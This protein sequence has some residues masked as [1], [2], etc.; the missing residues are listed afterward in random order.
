MGFGAVTV[1]G[2]Y[3]I[4]R[5]IGYQCAFELPEILFLSFRE[6]ISTTEFYALMCIL[7]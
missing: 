1:M 3:V 6:E 4:I 5:D 2:S 7:P